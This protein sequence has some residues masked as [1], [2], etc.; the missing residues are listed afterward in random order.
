MTERVADILGSTQPAGTSLFVL[1]VPSVTRTGDP[2]D[3]GYWVDQALEIFAT[4]FRGATAYPR[5]QGRWRDDEQGGALVADEPTIVT[6]YAAPDDIT[7]EAL[8]LLRGFLH[9][10]GREA[11]QGEVGI[12]FDGNYY[13]ITEYDGGA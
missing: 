10:L 5:G 2:I 4:L 1:F 11:A 3:H 7:D 8:A 13:G 9:R 6:C 12:V